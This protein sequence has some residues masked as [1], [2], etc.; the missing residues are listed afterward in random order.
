VYLGGGGSASEGAEG[1]CWGMF[2]AL[3]QSLS[4]T[5]LCLL[6][7]VEFDPSSGR[8]IRAWNAFPDC[9][10]HRAWSWR[11]FGGISHSGV[12]QNT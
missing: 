9:L 2:L 4:S 8:S 6:S 5:F 3:N 1:M 11:G 10:C 12:G 7:K